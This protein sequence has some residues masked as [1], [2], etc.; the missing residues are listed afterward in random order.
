MATLNP[1]WFHETRPLVLQLNPY[2]IKVRVL[3]YAPPAPLLAPHTHPTARYS[4]AARAPGQDL[5][6]FT[7]MFHIQD[8]DLLEDDD[9]M[10]CALFAMEDLLGSSPVR[11]AATPPATV[12]QPVPRLTTPHCA[13]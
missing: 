7:L 4:P 11:G 1:T 2:P 8:W 12:G 13:G 3:V 5:R 10:G 6:R 9:N